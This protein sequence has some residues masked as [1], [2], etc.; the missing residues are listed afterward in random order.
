MGG[1]ELSGYFT[2]M[3]KKRGNEVRGAVKRNKQNALSKRVRVKYNTTQRERCALNVQAYARG[4]ANCEL[5]SECL[6][7]GKFQ[8]HAE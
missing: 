4:H 3:W 7:S 5:L 8:I 1:S 2:D 6:K